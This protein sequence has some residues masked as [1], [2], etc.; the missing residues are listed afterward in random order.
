M[1][2]DRLIVLAARGA[3]RHAEVQVQGPL[4][5]SAAVGPRLDADEVRIVAA[6]P[7]ASRRAPCKGKKLAA[8]PQ[9]TT[10]FRTDER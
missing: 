9:F 6:N 2:G 3:G 5:K 1:P 10:S 8:E 4:D 7:A